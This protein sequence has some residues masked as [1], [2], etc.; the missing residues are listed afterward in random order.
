MAVR[1]PLV[2]EAGQIEQLQAGDTLDVTLVELQSLT[3]ANAGTINIGQPVYIS[4]ASSV[5][6]ADAGAAAT[7]EVIGLVFDTTILTTAT[8]S[9]L[10]EGV[11]TA[12]TVQWD[13]VTGGTGGL[14]PGSIYYLDPGTPG[15]LTLTAPTTTGQFVAPVGKALSTTKL[16]LDIKVT[17]KL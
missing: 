8:G 12:T 11:M 14:T 10:V 15:L 6:L 9:I 7:K 3:N 1:K 2:I 13:A 17:V 16:K 4:A 5:D